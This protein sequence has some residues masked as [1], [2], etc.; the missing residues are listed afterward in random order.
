ME[1]GGVKGDKR[2]KANKH[3]SGRLSVGDGEGSV[4]EKRSRYGL[5]NSYSVMLVGDV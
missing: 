2:K 3:N 4:R 1:G 5:L